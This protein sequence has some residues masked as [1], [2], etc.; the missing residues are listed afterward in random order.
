MVEKL[1]FTA[2]S[3]AQ[4]P[5]KLRKQSLA[6][7]D[8]LLV[9]APRQR[10]PK[11]FQGM[12]MSAQLAALHA[13]ATRRDSKQ[14]SARFQTPKLTGVTMAVTADEPA[15]ERLT[16]ARKTLARCMAEDSGKLGIVI[17]GFESEV[18]A[19]LL[20]A[21]VAAAEAASFRLPRF[22][23][24]QPRQRQVFRSISVYLCA[25]NVDL[26]ET[27][28]VARGNNIAR[29]LT[30]MPPNKL[31]AADYRATVE[32]IADS[33]HLSHEFLDEAELTSRGA[34]AFLAVSQGNA[35]RNAG[36]LHLRYTPASEP[37]GRLGLVGKGI[38]FDTGGN[39]LKPFKSM[40]EMH[41]DMQGSAVALGTLIALASLKVPYSIDCWLAITEN[42][43]SATAYKSQDVVR[44]SNGTTIQV[45]HTDAEGRMVLADTLA[46]ASSREPNLLIDYAT[47]TGTCISA[48][49]DRYSGVFSNRVELN[50]TL[51]SA[52]RASGER[53]WPFPLDADFDEP[54]RSDVAD[55]KQCA[56][57][58]SGDHIMATRFLS[59]F[60][61]DTIPWIHVD[62]SAAQHKGGLAHIPTEITGFGVRFSIEL[63]AR[64]L[65]DSAAF[66]KMLAQ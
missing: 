59:R 20:L 18:R 4:E 21:L 27:R 22:K 17:T 63:L 29:W 41:I 34:G 47:L 61:P 35:D 36:I 44:A 1:K 48:L 38:V 6:K 58:G 43:I 9:V 19:R 54:L 25:D 52:G 62:L 3:V 30:A 15:F 32:S 16:W 31:P 26:S 40:L 8:H 64:S 12:P 45:I 11:R 24:K 2:L 60:V 10:D 50:D 53:V 49:T 57:E 46:I 23:S 51:T 66:K 39:N 5:G 7:L 28:A 13:R 55:V 42:R 14:M 33:Y 65:A 56:V 37:S